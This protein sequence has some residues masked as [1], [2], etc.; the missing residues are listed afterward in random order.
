M[1]VCHVTSITNQRASAPVLSIT[2]DGVYGDMCVTIHSLQSTICPPA[3]GNRCKIGGERGTWN[4]TRI[5][6]ETSTWK[7]PPTT[8]KESSNRKRKTLRSLVR[9]EVIDFFSFQTCIVK[10]QGWP[11][12]CKTPKG[13]RLTGLLKSVASHPCRAARRC[14]TRSNESVAGIHTCC[15]STL[16]YVSGISLGVESAKFSYNLSNNFIRR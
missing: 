1:S 14:T 16:V 3:L 11:K 13:V 12:S 2:P 10:Q 9:L 4:S 7:C 5:R 6:S 8:G 15:R